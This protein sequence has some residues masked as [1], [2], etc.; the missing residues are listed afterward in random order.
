MY[1]SVPR[2]GL[3][4]VAPLVDIDTEKLLSFFV[5]LNPISDQL[6]HQ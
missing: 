4:E 2:G 6:A 3:A 1:L 5:P